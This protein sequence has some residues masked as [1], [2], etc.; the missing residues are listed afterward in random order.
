MVSV[1]GP[2][3]TAIVVGIATWII[4]PRIQHFLW[5]R[6]KHAE[7][8]LHVVEECAALTARFFERLPETL[9]AKVLSDEARDDFLKWHS[10]SVQVQALFSPATY[11]KFS[12]M[13]AI[14]SDHLGRYSPERRAFFNPEEFFPAQRD[15][16][17][18]LYDEMGMTA[19]KLLIPWWQFWKL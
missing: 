11:E 3:I 1:I 14:A 12:R 8:C 5:R 15:A 18:A 13:E 4:A 7:V 9:R 2:V 19:G 16:F 10:L 6:Q 17:R